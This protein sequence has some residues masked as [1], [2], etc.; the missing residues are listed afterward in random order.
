MEQNVYSKQLS[1]VAVVIA[2]GLLNSSLIFAQ[3]A[4]SINSAS[5]PQPGT[6]A[7]VN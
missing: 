6:Q 3:G 4:P 5:C 2:A 7:T 1:Y